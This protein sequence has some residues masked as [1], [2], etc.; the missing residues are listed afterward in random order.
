MDAV[1]KDGTIFPID[2]S[3]SE[4][5]IGE[6]RVFTAIIRDITE[7]KRA[8]EEKLQYELERVE[9]QKE[10]ELIDL[11]ERM[12]HTMTHELRTP[13]A[14]IHSSCEIIERYHDRMPVEK[15]LERI[16]TIMSTADYM[17]LLLNDALQ[18]AQGNAG[19]LP[20]NPEPMNLEA[21]CGNVF[22]QTQMSSPKSL[23]FA[24]DTSGDLDSVITDEKLLQ[25]ILYNLMSNAVKY[26]PEGGEV[27]LRAVGLPEEI[28]LEVTDTGRGIPAEDQPRIFEAF[29]RAN[30]SREVDGTGLG[31]A[32][33]KNAVEAHGGTISLC[34]TEGKGTSFTVRLPR[35]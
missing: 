1:R 14:I 31:L 24:L 32:I 25:S 20:F 8:E 26:T 9:M 6:H 18:F 30:N 17:V 23:K 22:E 5:F 34:S 7:R 12:I 4:S 19:R 15:Q 21:F 16:R 35:L 2:L 27:T 33:V 28:V 13:L 11:K 3:V 10:R 29:H